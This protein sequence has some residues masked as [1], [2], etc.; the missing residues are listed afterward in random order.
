MVK[1]MN[2][3]YNEAILRQR[4]LTKSLTRTVEIL[5]GEISKDLCMVK[6]NRHKVLAHYKRFEVRRVSR[7]CLD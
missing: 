1:T 2:S 4:C 3:W 5:I 7:P 6:R